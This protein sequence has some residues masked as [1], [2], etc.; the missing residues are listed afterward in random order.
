MNWVCKYFVT[1]R[2]KRYAVN[3]NPISHF[4]ACL[5]DDDGSYIKLLKRIDELSQLIKD[6]YE[7]NKKELE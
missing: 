2:I 1:Q 5:I 3:S 7:M 6:F 4:T